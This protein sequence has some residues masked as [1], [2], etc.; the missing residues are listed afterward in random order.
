MKRLESPR[1]PIAYTL[2]QAGEAVGLSTFPIRQAIE[3]GDLTPKYSGRKPLI[4]HDD[5]KAWFKS[6]PVARPE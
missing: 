6:L 5:L 4:D 1:V 3:A 2:D